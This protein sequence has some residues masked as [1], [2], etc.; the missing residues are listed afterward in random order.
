MREAM[1]NKNWYLANVLVEW[2][3]PPD[4]ERGIPALRTQREMNVLITP[5]KKKVRAQEIEDIRQLS[6]VKLRDHYKVDAQAISD[7]VI[8]N[9]IFLGTMSE[10]EYFEKRPDQE[11]V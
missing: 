9:I 6:M 8:R 3:S 1:M 7:I 10:K 2:V 5:S 4:E 11:A